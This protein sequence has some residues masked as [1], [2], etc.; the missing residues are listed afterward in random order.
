MIVTYLKCLMT[1]WNTTQSFYIFICIILFC[2]CIFN[3]IKFF[4]FFL[5]SKSTPNIIYCVCIDDMRYFRDYDD[6]TMKWYHKKFFTPNNLTIF[7]AGQVKHDT[8]FKALMPL[9]QKLISQEPYYGEYDQVY[10]FLKIFH[11]SLSFFFLL[12]QKLF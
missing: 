7:I 8:I 10:I 4:F 1:V 2:M 9:V 3:Y 6:K 12:K 11:F 5:N